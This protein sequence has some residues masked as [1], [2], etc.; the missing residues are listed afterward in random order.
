MATNQMVHGVATYAPFDDAESDFELEVIEKEAPQAPRK[1][2]NEAAQSKPK[3]YRRSKKAEASSDAQPAMSLAGIDLTDP[4][5]VAELVARYAKLNE[6]MHKMAAEK[7]ALAEDLEAEKRRVAACTD[8]VS[9]LKVELDKAQALV[10]FASDHG[11]ISYKR[12]ARR[13]L[14]ACAVTVGVMAVIG[15]L[16]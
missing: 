2:G 9:S 16:T 10:K 11:I 13:A 6:S 15:Y 1:A 5:Q 4:A 8:E 3:F 14:E 7:V 12:L